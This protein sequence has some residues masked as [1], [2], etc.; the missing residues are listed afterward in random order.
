MEASGFG[1]IQTFAFGSCERDSR[2]GGEENKQT[3]VT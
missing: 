2:V 3:Q 1:Q